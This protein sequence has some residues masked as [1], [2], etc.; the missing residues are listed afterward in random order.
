M[1]TWI[2]NLEVKPGKRDEYLNEIVKAGLI[3]KFRQH[4]GNIFYRIGRS[5]TDENAIIVCDAWECKEDFIAHDTSKDVDVWRE[6][7]SKY[8]VDCSSNLIEA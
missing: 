2:G 5:V 4:H 1:V 3:E 7:Y 8:V 6:I